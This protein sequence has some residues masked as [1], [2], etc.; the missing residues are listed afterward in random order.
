MNGL[1]GQAS[2]KR[3]YSDSPPGTL[4]AGMMQAVNGVASIKQEPHGPQFGGYLPDNLS[5]SASLNDSD[6]PAYE[7]DANGMYIDNTYRVIKWQPFSKP[8]WVELLD[9]GVKAVL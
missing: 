5:T 7:I 8:N 6:S 1:S 2:K 4:S 3:K 9:E